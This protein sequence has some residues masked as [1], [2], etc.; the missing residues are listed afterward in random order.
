MD[1]KLVITSGIGG[2]APV[3][4]INKLK[5]IEKKNFPPVRKKFY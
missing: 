4:E 5:G 3:K 2:E 1:S